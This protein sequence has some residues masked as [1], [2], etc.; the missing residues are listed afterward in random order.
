MI[1]TASL[2]LAQLGSVYHQAISL[3]LGKQGMAIL[4]YPHSLST[5]W[6]KTQSLRQRMFWTSIV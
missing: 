6:T 3:K 1:D 5:Y 2:S 4:L